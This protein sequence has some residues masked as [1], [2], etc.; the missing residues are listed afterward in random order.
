ME[1]RTESLEKY[2]DRMN[3]L[4]LDG[5]RVKEHKVVYGMG[6]KEKHA[7]LTLSVPTNGRNV[8]YAFSNFNK[9]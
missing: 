6:K 9:K 5:N 8:S 2:Q 1:K 4:T 7:H 3:K